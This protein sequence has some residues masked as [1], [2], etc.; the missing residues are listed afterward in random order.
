MCRLSCRAICYATVRD[1]NERNYRGDIDGFVL[2]SDLARS[3]ESAVLRFAHTSK[4]NDLAGSV[5]IHFGEVKKCF[6]Q[7]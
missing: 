3:I 5:V 2:M 6:L 1:K 4:C 7:P